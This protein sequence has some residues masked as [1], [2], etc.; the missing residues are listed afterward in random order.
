MPNLKVIASPIGN[1]GD[2]SQN[3]ISTINQIDYLFCEDTRV[4]GNLLNI[5]NIEKKPKLVSCHKF[6]E[7]ENIDSQME[8]IK[9]N[10]CGLISDAG[11]PCLSDPGYILVKTCHEENIIVEIID[12]PSAINHAIVQSGFSSNGFVFMGFLQKTNNDK[13]QQLD[14]LLAT[15]LPIVFFESVH[16]INQT[17]SF[18]KEIYP[19]NEVYIGRELSKKF[20]EY[21]VGRASEIK[22]FTLKGEFT[23]VLKPLTDEELKE[24]PYQEFD[25]EVQMLLGCNIKLK[26]ACKFIATK[27]KVKANYLYNHY[28][29]VK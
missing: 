4:T 2:I 11:Y 26:E 16:R 22:D 21:Y 20:E 10:R 17:V 14:S 19:D 12:G 1:L 24:L 6:N 23:L 28:M 9:N 8:L 13:R 3:F 25:K 5:L 27:Y 18:L 29:K 7:N 15:K